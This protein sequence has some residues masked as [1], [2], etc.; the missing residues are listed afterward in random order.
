MPTSSNNFVLWYLQGNLNL[1]ERNGQVNGIY[2]AY[3][4][5][6]LN[7]NYELKIIFY[8]IAYFKV[9]VSFA[10]TYVYFIVN[11]FLI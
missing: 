11:Y 5:D 10:L 3:R 1:G 8:L 7:L 6:G 4:S 2:F 9:K